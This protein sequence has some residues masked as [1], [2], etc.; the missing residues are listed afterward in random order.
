MARSFLAEDEWA[1]RGFQKKNKPEI[2]RKTH[3]GISAS[4]F[5]HMYLYLN[6]KFKIRYNLQNVAKRDLEWNEA[7]LRLTWWHLSPAELPLPRLKIWK[8][9]DDLPALEF[10]GSERCERI[11]KFWRRTLNSTWLNVYY[12]TLGWRRGLHRADRG[13]ESPLFWERE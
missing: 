6:S 12:F 2:S 1:F 3:I 8:A 5:R 11:A 4:P 13:M 7:Q 9:G 10:V